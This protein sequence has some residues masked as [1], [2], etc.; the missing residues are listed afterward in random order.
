MVR[1]IY[2]HRG[3]ERRIERE[4]AREEEGGEKER[5]RVSERE[6][7]RKREL[8]I[9]LYYPI[10]NL[11]TVSFQ[12]MRATIAIHNHGNKNE[13]S[14]NTALLKLNFTMRMVSI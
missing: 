10:S 13:P 7:E 4:G 5:N 14:I 1:E 8:H 12:Q 6:R 11:H 9:Y 3:M 2:I